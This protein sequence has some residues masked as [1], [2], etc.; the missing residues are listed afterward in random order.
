MARRVFALADT[1]DDGVVNSKELFSLVSTLVTGDTSQKL[2]FLFSI[3]DENGTWLN[4]P[5]AE[6][7]YIYI[8]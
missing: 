5:V 2:E 3:Y 8:L 1:N 7:T 4:I 6:R